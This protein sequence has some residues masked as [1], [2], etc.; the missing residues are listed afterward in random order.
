MRI[1]DRYIMRQVLLSV[2]M[3]ALAL[4]GFD[5]FFNLVQEL[6]V[7]GKGQYHLAEAFSY[8]LLTMPSRMYTLF[9]WA[10]LIGSLMSLGALANRSELVVMR[11]GGLSVFEITGAAIKAAACLTIF[12]FVLGEGFG[13]QAE[14]FAQAR[15]TWHLSGGQSMQTEAGLWIKQGLSFMHIQKIGSGGEVIG[16]TRYQ[17]NQ[18][19]DLE[20]ALFA[21]SARLVDQDW[22]LEAVQG[23]RFLGSKTESFAHATQ[24]MP[25]LVDSD[26]LEAAMVKHPERLSLL[27]LW[28]MM[29]HQSQNQLDDRAYAL[30]FWLKIFQPLVI[31]M[32]VFLGAPCIFGPLRSVS[33][34]SRLVAG[35]LI[36]FFFHTL[37]QILAPIAIVYQFPPILAVLLPIVFLSALGF[38]ALYRLR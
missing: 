9:P 32:M 37:N 24:V 10:A 11:T 22:I 17:F 5:Y 25:A 34:G 19:Y 2:S 31:M 12:M 1:I 36:A 4:A 21:G 35:L 29:R 30:A 38:W 3:A 23:T 18:H 14:H 15:R 7:I 13:P 16:L 6:K 27:A 20:E 26:I 28:K 8:L 33:M